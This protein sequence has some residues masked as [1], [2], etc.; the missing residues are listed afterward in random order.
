[1]RPS[2]LIAILLRTKGR[3]RVMREINPSLSA[4]A[5]SLSTSQ[6]TFMPASLQRA[7]P[8]PATSGLG[9]RMATTKR[10][11]PAVINASQHGGVR[12]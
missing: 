7:K 2:K 5:C 10:E 11:I 3:L 1:M 9:S 4:C 8:C 12:P 6:I